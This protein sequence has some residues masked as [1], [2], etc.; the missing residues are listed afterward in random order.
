MLAK[1]PEDR[2]QTPDELLDDLTSTSAIA[3]SD[4][5]PE[6]A[7]TFLHRSG[8]M[9]DLVPCGADAFHNPEVRIDAGRE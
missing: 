9:T 8:R 5:K 3:T 7:A 1:K 6:L 4:E 2:Y